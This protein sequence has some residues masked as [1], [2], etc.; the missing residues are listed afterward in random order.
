MR[1][2]KRLS[3]IIREIKKLRT[4]NIPWKRLY[5]LGLEY[6]YVSLYLRALNGDTISATTRRSYLRQEMVSKLE[7]AIWH[8]ARRQMTWWRRN[9]EIHWIKN[10]ELDKMT[11]L[12]YE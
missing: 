1:L 5:D 12:I 6:R 3:G 7:T 4:Q 11:V 9:K 2:I 8:Y 10:T